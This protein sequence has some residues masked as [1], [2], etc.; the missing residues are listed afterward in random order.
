MSHTVL[1]NAHVYQHVLVSPKQQQQHNK[2][3]YSKRL[4]KKKKKNDRG[5]GSVAY[6]VHTRSCILR[7]E[8]HTAPAAVS[9]MAS[10]STTPLRVPTHTKTLTHCRPV[11]AIRVPTTYWGVSQPVQSTQPKKKDGWRWRKAAE[12]MVQQRLQCHPKDLT[13]PSSDVNRAYKP[14]MQPDR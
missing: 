14:R 1:Y 4:S 5:W 12:M 8:T 6:H 13:S 7:P 11:Q 10:S 2:L 3:N 9:V